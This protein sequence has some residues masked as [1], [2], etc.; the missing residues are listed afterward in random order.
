MGEQL[1]RTLMITMLMLSFVVSGGVVFGGPLEDGLA[2][3]SRGD[4]ETALR[5][6]RPFA[7]QGDA[8]AQFDLGMMYRQGNG[9][10]KDQRE[11]AKWIRAA[12]ELGYAN[13]QSVLGDMYR[14]GSGVSSSFKEAQKWKRLGHSEQ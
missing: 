7:A 12:A 8:I 3:F 10:P 1:S 6:L 14:F 4:Y 13:A 11:A 5:L 2:A 9:V